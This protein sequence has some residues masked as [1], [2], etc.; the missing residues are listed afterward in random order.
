MPEKEEP[1]T[2]DKT[3]TR[4]LRDIILTEWKWMGRIPRLGEQTA[5][6]FQTFCFCLTQR[7]FYFDRGSCSLQ[8]VPASEQFSALVKKLEWAKEAE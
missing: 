4:L 8:I 1:T 7:G 2:E 6:S 3:V 5:I